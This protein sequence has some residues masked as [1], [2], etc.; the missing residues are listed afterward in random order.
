MVNYLYELKNV[1]ANHEKLVATGHITASQ[2]VKILS[3]NITPMLREKINVQ[4]TL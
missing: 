4:S 1:S 2:D 3:K